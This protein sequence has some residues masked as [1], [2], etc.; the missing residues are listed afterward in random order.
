M[1]KVEI[2]LF[3]LLLFVARCKQGNDK[4][5]DYPKISSNLNDKVNSNSK[6]IT[7]ILY[8]PNDYS[9]FKNALNADLSQKELETIDDILQGCIALYNDLKKEDIIKVNNSNIGKSNYKFNPLDFLIDLSQ[10]HRQYVAVYNELGEKE[11]FVNCFCDNTGLTNF[12][13]IVFVC[14]GGKCFFSV[15]INL[16]KNLYYNMR[17]NGPFI[18]KIRGI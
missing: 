6:K 4:K 14:D 18:G 12:D 11:V 15:I 10:Y 9:P 3:I 1:K 16:S 2:V 5:I 8:S 17:V 7:I 13:E